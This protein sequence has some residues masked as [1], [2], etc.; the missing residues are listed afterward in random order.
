MDR[1][2]VP[3]GKIGTAHARKLVNRFENAVFDL[4]AINFSHHTPEEIE[5]IKLRYE[6]AKKN[7]LTYIAR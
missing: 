4:T 7:L 1:Q 2:I 5:L 6:A 3:V